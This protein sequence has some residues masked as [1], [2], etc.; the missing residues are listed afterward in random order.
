MQR[1]APIWT[2]LALA[3]ALAA[4]PALAQQAQAEKSSSAPPKLE[5][6]DDNADQPITVIPQKPQTQITEKKEGGRTTE[7]H[8]K[9]GKSEYTVKAHTPAGNAQVGDA[10]TGGVRAPQWQVM[11]FDL[12]KRK[13]KDVDNPEKAAAAPETKQEAQPAKK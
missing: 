3:G 13:P 10:Q 4:G 1:S 5:R 12:N 2:L 6:I 8:V 9:A 7:A 11:E